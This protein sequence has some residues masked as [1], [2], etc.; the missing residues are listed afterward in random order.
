[1]ST[2][3][4][5][6]SNNFH[7]I[8][9]LWLVKSD[10]SQ[11][12]KCFYRWCWFSDSDDDDDVLPTHPIPMCVQY[13]NAVEKCLHWMILILWKGS[14]MCS[15]EQRISLKCST[16]EYI[17]ICEFIGCWTLPS[18]WITKNYTTYILSPSPHPNDVNDVTF[19]FA[20]LRGMFAFLFYTFAWM[21]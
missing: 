11:S 2:P 21:K 7:H 12:V 9:S 19:F 8:F 15:V 10:E 13:K 17:E 1:M 4:Q 6:L 20:Y 14:D 18:P 5:T 3:G 16:C